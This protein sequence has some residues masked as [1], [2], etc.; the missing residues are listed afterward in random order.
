MRIATNKRGGTIATPGS[1]LFQFDRKGVI[2]I[3]KEILSEESLF[4]IALDWGVDELVT[5][6]EEYILFT[7]VDD[8]LEVKQKLQDKGV[9]IS[10]A[11]FEQ[12][13][14]NLVEV[15]EENRKKMK[16][17]LIGLKTL[18]MWI[19]SIRIW[20]RIQLQKGNWM[21]VIDIHLKSQLW[22][23]DLLTNFLRAN[24]WFF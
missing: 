23:V 15:D 20:P 13:P 5:S 12:I 10:E 17:S 18:T 2:R 6:D 8:L 14:K 19:L 4:L 11:E 3:A 24:V 22:R 7:H 1:V 21:E 9:K 16:I